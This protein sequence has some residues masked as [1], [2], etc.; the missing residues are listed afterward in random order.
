MN[1]TYVEHSCFSVELDKVVLIFDYFK[2][3]LPDFDLEKTIYV[4]SSH[5]HHDHFNID[6]FQLLNKYPNVV[7]IFSKD[8]KKKFGRKFFNTHG[9][10]DEVYEKIE[11]IDINKTLEISDLKIE[12]LNSTDEGVAFIVTA[13]DKTIYHAGNL[14]LWWWNGRDQKDNESARERFEEEINKIKNR[15][16]DAAFVVLDPRQGEEFYLGF[17]YFMKNTNTDKVFPMHFWG[18]SSVIE[19]LKEMKCSEDYR[20]KIFL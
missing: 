4:F 9:V 20:N 1:I 13:E 19:R 7:Y 6:I 3:Q 8:I 18:D 5:N 2:G 17:D 11:F 16:F 10:D 15:H 14:N 12:T